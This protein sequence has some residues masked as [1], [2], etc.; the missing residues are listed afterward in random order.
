[1][2][3][4]LACLTAWIVGLVCAEAL[5]PGV[6][7]AGQLALAGGAAAASL[8]IVLRPAV[9]GLTLA[10]AMFGV[11]RAELPPFDP[12]QA[13]SAA[14]LSGAQVAVQGS[15]ADDPRILTS[16]YEVLV[17]MTEVATHAGPQPGS[18]KLLAQVKGGA[19]EP[20]PGDE[21]EVVGTLELPRDRPGFDR[22]AYLAQR[23]AYLEMRSAQLTLVRRAGGPR[24]LPGWLRD[25][26]REAIQALLPEPHA[27]VLVGVVLGVRSG[28]PPR[29]AQDLVAT[30]LVHLLVLSGLKV[31]VFARLASA[32]LAP[33][34]GRAATIPTLALITLYA[35]A[36]GATPAALR[37]AAMGGLALAAA[38]LGRPTHVWTSLAGT[39]AAMLAWRP[40]LTWDVGFQLSFAGT[41]AIVVLTP[42]LERRLRWMPGWLREPF[43]VTCA[44]QVGT[45][46]FMAANFHLLSPVGP[47][48]NAA[49]LPLLPAMIAAGLLMAPLAAFPDVGRVVVLPLAG[50]LAYLEQVA[51]ALARLPAAALPVPDFPSWVGVA[52]YLALGG[53]V[54]GAHTHGLPRRAALLLGVALPLAI[55][56]IELLAWERPSSSAAVLAVGDGQAILL[57]GP[58]G[59]VLVDG[60]A[61]PAK[62]RSELGA[63]LPPWQRKLEALVITGPGLKHVGGLA[64]MDLQARLAIVPAGGFGGSAE[65]KAALAAIAG[66]AQLIEATAGQQLAVAGLR[67]QVL[68]PEPRPTEPGQ[69]ALRATGP[70][71]R[72]FCDVADL[73]PDSQTL[74]ASR[75]RGRCDYL[76]LP[77]GGRSAPAPDLLAAARASRLIV[78]DSGGRLAR[79]LP[80]ASTMRTSQEGTIVLPL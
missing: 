32:A 3:V 31:A 79:D 58:G 78:S 21:V 14:A 59:Q 66:G 8:S 13:A 37:A 69:L 49:V 68:A 20:A 7:L 29:L 47:I 15:V 42:A 52:Y 60:G 43:A 74:A 73:D 11:A 53:A 63:R 61:S 23:G 36:G 80:S 46:P 64:E 48:A 50:L 65:R 18:G 76:L 6:V 33:L 24:A 38:H 34:L 28:V 39:G 17:T 45:V 1:M 12:Q 51:G 77:S 4:A 55:G 71:G 67:I 72:S 10:A 75:L 56:G 30:G 26:Y 40:E 57:S 5:L 70:S 35:L 62:L 16:G 22:R 25:R 9:V 27:A 19:V 44:A 2:T 54:I 41:A